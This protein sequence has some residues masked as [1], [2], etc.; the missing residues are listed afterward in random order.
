MKNSSRF[1]ASK[2]FSYVL[3]IGGLIPVLLRQAKGVD[4][5]ELVERKVSRSMKEYWTLFT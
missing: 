4:I 2:F 1:Q 3:Y 5:L